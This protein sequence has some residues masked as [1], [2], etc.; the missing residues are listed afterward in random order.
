MNEDA[1]AELQALRERAYGPDAD[2]LRDPVAYDRLHELEQQLRTEQQGP[3]RSG[4]VA[5]PPSP[6]APAD[7][8]TQDPESAGATAASSDDRASESVPA[9]LGRPSRGFPRSRAP[10]GSFRCW[11]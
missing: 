9:R 8:S 11:R 1:A 6:D 5:D 2:I 10:S 7:P 3:E 4:D